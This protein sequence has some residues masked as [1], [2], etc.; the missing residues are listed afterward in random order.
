MT[1][2]KSVPLENLELIIDIRDCITYFLRDFQF[3]DHVSRRLDFESV[4]WEA[5]IYIFLFLFATFKLFCQTRFLL[6]YRLPNSKIKN[7]TLHADI[8]T[9]K[10]KLNFDIYDSWWVIFWSVNRERNISAPPPPPHPPPTCETLKPSFNDNCNILVIK[11][12]KQNLLLLFYDAV[13]TVDVLTANDN[14][15]KLVETQETRTVHFAWLKL[16]SRFERIN[17]FD[18]DYSY[19]K[20]LF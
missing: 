11:F 2:R 4:K 18:R 20:I 15:E 13:A 3:W 7:H 1:K 10:L 16:L 5:A 17:N 9:L 12:E 6:L 14:D 19:W 8:V